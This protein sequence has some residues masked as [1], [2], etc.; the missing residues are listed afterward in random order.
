MARVKTNNC[1][2]AYAIEDAAAAVFG[3]LPTVPAWKQIEPND[4]GTFGA[5]IS[6]VARYPISK[7]RQRRKGTITDLDSSVEIDCDLTLDSFVD[8]VEGFLFAQAAGAP[9]FNVTSVAAAGDIFHLSDGD[10][11]AG[12][13]VGSLIATRGFT[14][15]GNNTGLNGVAVVTAVTA[16]VAATDDLTITTVPSDADT[17]TLGTITYTWK[18]TLSTA[19]TVAY[20]VFLGVDVTACALNLSRAINLTGT[21]GTEYSVGTAIHPTC[22]SSPA[23]GVLTATSNLTG[24]LGNA[25]VATESGATQAWGGAGVLA[26]GVMATVAATA[27]TTVNETVTTASCTL[28]VAGYRTAV[29]DLDVNSDGNLVTT[30]LNLT[31]LG[32]E[33]GQFIYIG[34]ALT[35]NKFGTAANNGYARISLAPTA[36]LLTLDKKATTFVAEANTTLYVDMYFGR[37]IRNVDVDDADYIE[38]SYQFEMAYPDLNA[39]GTDEYEYALGNYCDEVSFELPLADK[40]GVKYK[41]IGTDTEVPTTSRKTNASTAKLPE[42]TVAY[43]TTQDL[44]RLRITQ[45]D[46]TGLTTDFKD[47]T[48]KLANSVSPEKVLGQLGAKYMNSGIFEVDL[49]TSCLFTSGDVTDAIRNNTTVTMDFIMANDDGAI[50]VDIPSMTLGDGAKEFPVNETVLIGVKGMAFVDPTLNTSVGVSIF[51]V[52]PA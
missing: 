14:N 24:T 17:V 2:L 21:A 28:D 11:A 47:I 46:E 50:V 31:T 45:T 25:I 5:E 13:I 10:T 52:L 42:M 16:G 41:F 49:E 20:E 48:L 22:T 26:G 27:M 39:V 1:T 37:F 33:A 40:A 35:A 8:F 3:T 30:A 18:T 44:A 34:G 15:S 38:R 29:G 19:P 36:N 4:I 32:L 9:S 23:A 43:N 51:P 12:C 7:N 6:T